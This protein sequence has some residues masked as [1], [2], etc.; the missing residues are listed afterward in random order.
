MIGDCPNRKQISRVSRRVVNLASDGRVVS[1]DVPRRYGRL[2]QLVARF[3][4][5]EEVVGSSPASPT[6]KPPLRRGF[7]SVRDTGIEPVTSSVSGKR[8][9]AA[10]IAPKWA[11]QF[12]E[13]WRR[14]SNPCKRL[15]RPVP[16]RSATPPCGL[17]PRAEGLP[18]KTLYTRADDETRTRDPNLGKVVRYQLR[19]IRVVPGCC[20]GHI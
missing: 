14:D 15:C 9:T 6:M 7:S 13:R 19:Y 3:L 11:V 20:P 18:K 12:S 1:V 17:T 8:A 4:H 10:P 2:A 16:S 5:T